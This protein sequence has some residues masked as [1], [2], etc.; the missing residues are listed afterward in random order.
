MQPTPVHA[1]A[2][3]PARLGARGVLLASG[4]AASLLYVAA[5]GLAALRWEGYRY[6]DQ[7]VSELMAIGAPTRPLLLAPFSLYN[8]LMVAFALGVWEAAGRSRALRVSALVL[9]AWAVT[10]WV[11]LLYAPMHLRG[12]AFTTTDV[13]HI[14]FTAVGALLMMVAMGFAAAALRR[15]FRLYTIA[16]IAILL[17]FGALAGMY[18]A[19]V[20]A[21]RPTPWAGALERVDIYASMLWFALLAVVLLR[22]GAGGGTA[23]RR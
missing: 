9:L 7:M 18:G 12:T 14:V 6:T 3:P 17:T 4:I 2:G 10:G 1:N 11:A 13:M 21:G 20:A 22:A 15:A 23:A 19:D 16:T 8:A 5:D